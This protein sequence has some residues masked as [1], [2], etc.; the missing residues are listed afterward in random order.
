EHVNHGGGC[1]VV[2]RLE[3]ARRLGQA[4]EL[5]ELAPRIPLGKTSAHG[6]FVNTVLV[7]MT[8]GCLDTTVPAPKKAQTSAKSPCL[9]AETNVFGLTLDPRFGTPKRGGTKRPETYSSCR[10]RCGKQW[11]QAMIDEFSLPGFPRLKRG[12]LIYAQNWQLD[13]VECLRFGRA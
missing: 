1:H 8:R 10:R 12:F 2:A 9:Y 11:R 4:I 13:P 6:A 5:D 3:I 7:N